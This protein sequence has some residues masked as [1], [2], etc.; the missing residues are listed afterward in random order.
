MSA[1]VV[2]TTRRTRATACWSC[3]R[4]VDAVSALHEHA[5]K[6]GDVSVCAYCGALMEFDAGGLPRR[7]DDPEALLASL[8]EE[9]R[10]WVLTLQAHFGGGARA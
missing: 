6:E 8:P 9:Q 3:G 5:P 4:H 2:V 7:P 10:G 1:E